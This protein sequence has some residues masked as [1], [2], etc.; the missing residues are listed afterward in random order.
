MTNLELLQLKVAHVINS[1]ADGGFDLLNI[2]E[3]QLCQYF[4]I[5]WDAALPF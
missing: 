3:P 5:T 4:G 1:V 2:S